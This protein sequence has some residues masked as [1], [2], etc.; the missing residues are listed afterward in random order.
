MKYAH[1]LILLGGLT[2]SNANAQPVTGLPLEKARICVTGFDHNRPDPFPGLGDFIGW[3]GDTVRLK[4]GDLLFTHSAG[5]WHVSFAT[6]IVLSEN[7][8]EPYK[9]AGLDLNHKAPT[10]GRIMACRSSDNGKTWSKP[11]LVYD[12]KLDAG[13]S[14]TCVTDKGTVIQIIN[15]QASWYGFPQAPQGHQKLNTRQLTIRSTD[16]GRTWSKPQPLNSSGTYYTRGR[17]RIL[18]LPDGGLLW[19]CYNMNQGGGL[20]DGAIHRSD[21]DG[22]TWRIASIIRRRQP[23]GDQFDAKNLVVSGDVDRFLKLGGPKDSDPQDGDPKDGGW[24]DTDEGDL[25]RLSSGRLVLVV[26]PDGGTLVSD[27]QAKTWKQISRVGPKYVYAPH[28]VVLDDDTL[29]LTA[30]GGGGQCVFLS[31]DGG[32]SWSKP[33]RIDP[34]CYGYGKLTLL[35]DETILL[36]YVQKHSAPQ[37]CMLVRFKVN[38]SRDG[39]ELLAVGNK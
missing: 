4:N 1:L 30:G 14:A 19:M 22:K 25:G 33:I 11:E 8:V 16:H 31:T 38:K 7:L 18:Q 6:P 39:V 24:I 20:L 10:G 13:P 9:K 35:E 36:A 37:R 17:S 26:R 29:V 2:A 27:D 3:V 12:G 5:Y 23:K 34:S 15:V 21:D 32:K 28:L